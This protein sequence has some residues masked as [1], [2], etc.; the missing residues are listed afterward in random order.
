MHRYGEGLGR[1]QAGAELA[2][3]EEG[4]HVAEGDAANEV[5]DVDAPVA[6]RTALSIGFGDLGLEGDHAL[7]ARL[8]GISGSAG[9]VCV[10]LGSLRSSDI[11]VS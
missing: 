6:Q 11:S 3:D 8:E 2:I 4:P 5:L 1:R 7:E 9:R 10:P